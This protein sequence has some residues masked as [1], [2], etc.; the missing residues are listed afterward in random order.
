MTKESVGENIAEQTTRKDSAREVENEKVGNAASL[1]VIQDK[2]ENKNSSKIQKQQVNTRS[3]LTKTKPAIPTDSHT[4][5]KKGKESSSKGEDKQVKNKAIIVVSTSTSQSESTKQVEKV[6]PSAH[7]HGGDEKKVSKAAGVPATSAEILKK[8]TQVNSKQLAPEESNKPMESE[9]TPPRSPRQQ[10]KRKPIKS[11]LFQETIS[12]SAYKRAISQE[13]EARRRRRELK[14][15]QV[16]LPTMKETANL[17]KSMKRPRKDKETGVAKRARKNG[18]S[19]RPP[20][21][22][23]PIRN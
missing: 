4:N 7:H 13:Q 14:A 6:S 19:T 12:F 5:V 22:T 17:R 8:I 21:S 10:K 1:K 3:K 2:V 23:S 16:D 9:N 20:F 18:L 15:K 11:R